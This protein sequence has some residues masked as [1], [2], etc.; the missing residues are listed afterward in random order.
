MHGR[1]RLPP[2][3]YALVDGGARVLAL[4]AMLH[5]GAAALGGGY[6][7]RWLAARS[8]PVGWKVLMVTGVLYALAMFVVRPR[9]RGGIVAA[10]AAAVVL[11][12][13][14]LVDALASLRGGHGASASPVPLTL[15][16]AAWLF[17][18]VL[19]RRARP[20]VRDPG[21]PD[22]LWHKMLERAHP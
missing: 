13:L 4:L 8:G 7:P 1:L 19:A 16:L 11:A 20:V 22:R 18:W 9:V 17:A 14:C 21:S 12:S 10:R 6:D 2:A 15:L 5:A 3:T